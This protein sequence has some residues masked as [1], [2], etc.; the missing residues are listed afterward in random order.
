VVEESGESYFSWETYDAMLDRA[1]Q[2]LRERSPAYCEG[3]GAHR[4][5]V[6]RPEL[7]RVGARKTAWV[8]FSKT[9]SGLRRSRES[10]MTF[11]VSETAAQGS[12]VDGSGRLLLKGRFLSKTVES[13][14]KR[15]VHEYVQCWVCKS[16]HTEMLRNVD[17]RLVQVV[18][19]MCRSAR[20]VQGPAATT[21]AASTVRSMQGN[22]A[23]TSDNGKEEG[24]TACDAAESVV[25]TASTFICISGVHS[26]A[27][28]HQ[29]TLNIGAIG[30]VAHGKSTIV[31]CLS[32]TKTGKFKKEMVRDST[33][34]LGY[35]NT[36]IFA[37][38]GDN[39]AQR[40][41]C[42]SRST[43]NA[44]GNMVGDPSSGWI[45]QRHISFVDCPGHEQFMSTM[46]SGAAVMDAVLLVI[47]ADAPCPQPQTAEHLAAIEILGLR[48]VIIVQ[49]KIDLVTP[50]RAREH[51][52]QI[53]D[54]VRGTC[55]QG[56][57]VVPVAANWEVNMDLVSST[58]AQCVP[59]PNRD[60]VTPPC[61]SVIRSFDVNKPGATV[62]SLK[63]AVVGGSL[64]RGV[65]QVGDEV[66]F[67][68]GVIVKDKEGR[69]TQVRPFISK[70][71]SLRAEETSLKSAVPGGLI[72]V[73]TALDPALSKGNGLVGQVMGLRGSLPDVH[74]AITV[75]YRRLRTVV[76]CHDSAESGK[77]VG[78]LCKKE[79]LL[80]SVG[81]S[82][83]RAS[84]I[85]VR[86]KDNG[87]R[88]A[89]LQ[90]ADPVCCDI[91]DRIA[92]SRLV[93]GHWR[94]SGWAEILKG[95]KIEVTYLDDA[96]SAEDRNAQEIL[97]Q[98]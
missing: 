77:A 49:T 28:R 11:I 58:I 59:L 56:A 62:A 38:S 90:L 81:S 4:V 89:Y 55:A 12:S 47:A 69:V 61:M 80:L 82:T 91:G 6:C 71:C 75:C 30:H 40:E 86:E 64:T 50:D 27:M 66:E 9:C 3:H 22:R 44:K 20:V 60:V 7:I 65:L 14:L 53:L 52:Q 95:E 39:G 21:L 8:N 23:A 83:M 13:L 94:L 5:T 51:L 70:V 17:L 87:D 54:F 63:G 85:R 98:L 37:T 46:I 48:S 33:I 76:G 32:G 26:E 97:D 93:G 1:V 78:K 68:P 24:V 41:Y 16:C 2:Q 36:K 88:L 43:C 73:G 10:I 92:F 96:T 45:L 74:S 34:Q 19:S 72:G 25:A 84:V 42:T 15:Y 31:R 29:A 18:C 35:A 79:V 57:A 67:R